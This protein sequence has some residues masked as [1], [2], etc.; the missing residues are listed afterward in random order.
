MEQQP[1]YTIR[2]AA[3]L[4]GVAAG[5]IREYERQGLLRSHRDRKN[6]HRLFTGHELR[7]IRQIRRLI[8]EEGLNYEGVRRLLLVNPCWKVHHCQEG[9]REQ[10]HVYSENKI[11]C[12]ALPDLPDCCLRMGR[13]CQGCPVYLDAGNQPGLRFG[14]ERFGD[15]VT[16]PIM[17]K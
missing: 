3:Q 7:W 14:Q 10:C 5:T 4:T 15:G 16:V 12:W 11:P 9:I 13:T 6:N 8:H 2:I 17:T 1:V